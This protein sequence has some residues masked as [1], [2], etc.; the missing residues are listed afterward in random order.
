MTSGWDRRRFLTALS[1][2]V[3]GSLAGCQNI[4]GVAS[5][6]DSSGDGDTVTD[7][8][9]TTSEQTNTQADEDP[10]ATRTE[11]VTP[12]ETSVDAGEIYHQMIEGVD[13]DEEAL[14]ITGET[15]EERV[16]QAAIQGNHQGNIDY[17]RDENYSNATTAIYAAAAVA[18]LDDF[19][20]SDGDIAAP[21]LIYN[22]GQQPGLL[23]EFNDEN[24]ERVSHLLNAQGSHTQPDNHFHTNWTTE[25]NYWDAGPAM[26]HILDADGFE[27]SFRNV[28]IDEV[29]EESYETNWE[30]FSS[31]AY[32][33][34]KLDIGITVGSWD[35]WHAAEQKVTEGLAKDVY[36]DLTEVANELEQEDGVGGF[37][38]GYDEEADE[39][40]AEVTV[41]NE[42]YA[43][44]N[45][46]EHLE[47]VSTE[48]AS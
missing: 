43:E 41:T 3:T 17:Q 42:E 33:S 8:A 2:T 16:R 20:H 12:S 9:E 32:N 36:D 24:G 19:N 5:Q 23:L 29:A 28:P 46:F 4:G 45:P 27:Q 18:S 34:H 1:L 38:F 26:S 7:E 21:H 15:K 31:L 14:S 10:T 11:T 44:M 30:L 6:T 39:F 37:A 48:T 22:R 25:G 13:L 35:A 40:T 47:P